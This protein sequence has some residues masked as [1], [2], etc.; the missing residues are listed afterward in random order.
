M[1]IFDDMWSGDPLKNKNW[2]ENFEKEMEEARI[3]DAIRDFKDEKKEPIKRRRD[4]LLEIVHNVLVE[5]VRDAL[6]GHDTDDMETIDTTIN[7]RINK[8]QKS[9]DDIN[10]YYNKKLKEIDDMKV[11]VERRSKES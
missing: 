4:L 8:F 6:N 10:A 7:I 3:K 2:I 5:D 9:I 1:N 11:K